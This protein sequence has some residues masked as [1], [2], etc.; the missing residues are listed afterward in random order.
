MALNA[1]Q[2]RFCEEYLVDLNAT[3]AAI[4]AGYSVKTAKSQGSRLLTNA[5]VSA[6][7]DALKAERSKRT[8]I[9]ADRVLRELARVAFV[10]PTD[11]L[12]MAKAK[13]RPDVTDHDRAVIAGVKVKYIP[14]KQY[15][16]DG[17]MTVVDAIERE[18]KLADKLRALDMLAKHLNMYEKGQQQ[19]DG[20][21]GEAAET[22]VVVMP[23]VMQPTQPPE[24]AEEGGEA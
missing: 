1:K 20:E 13:V 9:T 23:P 3:Q 12:E 6:R 10:D 2:E 19:G 21:D 11:V 18:V 5:D 22:G 4:R 7:V 8:E 24:I 15:D 14:V 17:E 16:E